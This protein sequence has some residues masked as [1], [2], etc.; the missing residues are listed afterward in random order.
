MKHKDIWALAL[1]PIPATLGV[2]LLWGLV[3]VGLLR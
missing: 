3:Q 2:L 1:S